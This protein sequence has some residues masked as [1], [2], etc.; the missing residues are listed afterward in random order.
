MK[1]TV[2]ATMFAVAMVPAFS[3][4]ADGKID[5]TGEV[6]GQTCKINNGAPNM[7]VALPKVS[8]TTLKDAGATAGNTVFTIKLT[9]CSPAS[10]SAR[11]YFEPGPTVDLATGRLKLTNTDGAKNVQIG[12]AN[13]SGEEIK[14]GQ[15]GS[16]TN[17]WV[18]IG[19]GAADL[20]YLAR[21]V[22][23][24]S[25]EAGKVASNVMYTIEFQ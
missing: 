14:I 8:T 9:E 19:S 18:S 12:L 10:G 13:T 2:L 5:F 23:L 25:A 22:S 7:T 16:T 1:K 4:A 3:Y 24:G 21:Y 6:T 15:S 17:P 20:P 11:A